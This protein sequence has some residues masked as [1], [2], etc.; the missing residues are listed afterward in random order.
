MTND[1][2][3]QLDAQLKELAITAQ[4][5]TELTKAKRIALTR[6]MNDIKPLSCRQYAKKLLWE[7]LKEFLEL[8]VFANPQKNGS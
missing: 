2:R 6:L 7:T 8:I 3:K 1:G 4:Q 5:Y